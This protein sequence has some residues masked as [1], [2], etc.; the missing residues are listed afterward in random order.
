[1][2]EI[3]LACGIWGIFCAVACSAYTK[4]ACQKVRTETIDKTIKTYQVMVKR[5]MDGIQNECPTCAFSENGTLCSKMDV[6]NFV[7]YGTCTCYEKKRF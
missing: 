2:I 1:M 7:R 5:F 3:I 4:H 6:P